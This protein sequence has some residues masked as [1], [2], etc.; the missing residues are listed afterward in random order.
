MQTEFSQRCFYQLLPLFGLFNRAATGCFGV[1]VKL[2][3]EQN[4]T[5]YIPILENRYCWSTWVSKA[6]LT[7]RVDEKKLIEFLCDEL[8]LYLASL[9][10]MPHKL[11]IH[12]MV[13]SIFE[14]GDVPIC[15]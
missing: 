12:D 15:D 13:G 14:S 7:S 4:G 11:E 1:N 3:S 9:R 10:T 5:P 8:F 2:K 6:L